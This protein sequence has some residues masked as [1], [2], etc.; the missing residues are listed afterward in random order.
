MSTVLGVA[1]FTAF[2]A[3][4]DPF[5]AFE[6]VGSFVLAGVPLSTAAISILTRLATY[7]FEALACV[8]VALSFGVPCE[9]LPAG[10]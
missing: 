1:I 5:Q 2:L 8:P 3:W 7:W 6:R 9:I 10:G 4:A